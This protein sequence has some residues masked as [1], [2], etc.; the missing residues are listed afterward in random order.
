MF[1]DLF[2]PVVSAFNGTGLLLLAVAVVA[3]VVLG[4][5]LTPRA[6]VDRRLRRIAEGAGLT[7]SHRTRQ[8]EQA[9]SFP[10]VMKRARTPFGYRLTVALP[11]GMSVE[12]VTRHDAELA[13]GLSAQEVRVSRGSPGVAVLEVYVRDATPAAFDLDALHSTIRATGGGRD[14]WLPVGI[15]DDGSPYRVGLGHLLIVGATGSGKGSALW[16]VIRALDA[17]R[18]EG[19]AILY[20]ID[21]KRAELVGVGAGFERVEYDHAAALAV[22]EQVGQVMGER[23]LLG[24]RS[25]KATVDRPWLVLVLDEFNGLL[26]DPEAARRRRI[27]ELLH[28]ILSQGRSLGVVVVA[29]AQNAQKESLG[30]LRTH[31]QTRIVLRVET[32]SDVDM[33]LGAGSAEAGARA[34]EIPPATESNG[35][36]TAGVAYA[37]SDGEPVPV[38]FRFP[39]VRDAE[40]AAWVEAAGRRSD[41]GRA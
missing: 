12:D 31:F 24:L 3:L 18:S 39:F 1:A 26:N 23:K 20:G 40:I 17:L 16:S 21:P 13:D 2:G 30:Q 27:G 15:R 35:Y 19:L 29:A 10:R 11:S 14:L 32:A 41:H 5:F 25:F 38:R 9:V 4:L 33:V 6:F 37:R 22:L 28:M 36:A 34:H 7:V 8:G